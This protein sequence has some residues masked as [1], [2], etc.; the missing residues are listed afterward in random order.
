MQ[1]I[2]AARPGCSRVEWMTD[3]DNDDARAFCHG[4]GFEEFERKVNYRVNR[5]S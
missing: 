3:R 5:S 2:A 1:A 4:L